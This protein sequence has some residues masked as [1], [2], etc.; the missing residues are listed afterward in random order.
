MKKYIIDRLIS[1]IIT[2]LILSV[3][4]FSLTHIMS[5]DP[6]T[7][8]LGSEAGE[9]QVNA[10]RE[11]MGLND[12]IIIQYFRWILNVIRGNFGDSYFNNNSVNELIKAHF[13]ASVMLAVFAEIVALVIAIPMGVLAAKHKN[14]W[15]DNVISAVSLFGLSVPDF[16]IALILVLIFAVKI[17]LFHVSGYKPASEGL[18]VYFSYMALPVLALGLRQ[19]ALIVRTTRSSLLDVLNLDYIKTAKSKGLSGNKILYKHA[20]RNAFITIITVIGQS[21]GSLIAGTAVVESVFGIPGMGQLIVSSILKRDYPTIQG[22][23]LVIGV[24]YI[25]IN[26]I[27]D[28]LYG[29]INPRIRISGLEK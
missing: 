22:V 13:S 14:G 16:I 10:L 8:I 20:L 19:A 2:L 27:T 5:G 21:F 7:I 23:I 4:A 26:L 17:K 25:L 11:S 15:Q 1:V 28:L 29:V 3:L 12:N 9:E 24:I 6:A 18:G